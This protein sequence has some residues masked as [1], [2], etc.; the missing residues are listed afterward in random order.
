MSL[1]VFIYVL[2]KSSVSSL[3][4]IITFGRLEGTWSKGWVRLFVLMFKSRLLQLEMA[5]PF[6]KEAI[7]VLQKAFDHL[8]MDDILLDNQEASVLSHRVNKS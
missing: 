2:Y 5:K 3:S 8:C 1:E 6:L 4:L 7:K